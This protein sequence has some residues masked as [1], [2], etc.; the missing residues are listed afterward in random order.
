MPNCLP[1]TGLYTDNVCRTGLAIF[2]NRG[3]KLSGSQIR[4]HSLENSRSNSDWN[5]SELLREFSS[6]WLRICD[7]DSFKPL[8]ANIAR[9]VLQTLSVYSPVDGKQFGIE[10]HYMVHPADDSL[11]GI[12]DIRLSIAKDNRHI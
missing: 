2:A 10:S 8:L 3:L 11:S 6:E 9:P 5:H 4:N 7:P 1:S 12:S